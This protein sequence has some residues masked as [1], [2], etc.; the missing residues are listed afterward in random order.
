M[1][2]AR[3]FQKATTSTSLTRLKPSVWI[4]TNCGKFIKRWEL[5]IT[6]P[7]SDF[8]GGSD[9]KASVYDA[10]DLGSIPGLGRSLEKEMAI[11]SS[12]IAWKIPWTEEPGRLQSMGSPRAGHDWATSLTCLLKNLYAGQEAIVRTRHGQRID[13]KLGKE[14]IKDVYC[15]PA[16]STYMQRISCKMLA[17]MTHKLESR[18]PGE[19][20]ASSNIQMIPL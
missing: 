3:E 17:W 19:I 20:P 9:S 12:T 7:V 18:L 8:P 14:Y 1:E 16:Y 13:S 4:T 11:H 6:L 5:Q 10:G 15:H 2:K